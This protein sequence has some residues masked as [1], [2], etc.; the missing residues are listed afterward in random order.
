MFSDSTVSS[1]DLGTTERTVGV[2]IAARVDLEVLYAL[3]RRVDAR[4][5]VQ[6]NRDLVC[7]G[8]RRVWALTCSQM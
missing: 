7:G 8:P 4:G 2:Q 5:A 1:D 6:R 3:H